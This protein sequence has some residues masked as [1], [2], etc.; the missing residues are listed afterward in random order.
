MVF[1]TPTWA[2]FLRL[3]SPQLEQCRRQ[4]NRR[5]NHL[6]ESVVNTYRLVLAS[7]LSIVEQSSLENRFRGV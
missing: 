1:I 5:W 2:D 7:T 4:N 3:V 6:A